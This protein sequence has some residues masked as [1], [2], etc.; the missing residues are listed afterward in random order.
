MNIKSADF[1]IS[2]VKSPQFPKNKLPEFAFIGRSNV[3][4]SSLINML[5]NRKLLAKTS[6]KP[7]KTRLLNFFCINNEWNLVDMPGYGYAKASKTNR[8]LFAKI[9]AEYLKV[10]K[11]LIYLFILI[12][13]RH[14]P[15]NTDMEFIQQMAQMQ[16][17]FVFV[18]TKTDKLSKTA[19]EKS[20]QK[21][22]QTLDEMFEELP[23]IFLASSVSCMGREELLSFIQKQSQLY[24]DDIKKLKID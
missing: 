6:S 17:P 9:I 10:R 12:D 16:I 21:Y 11:S 4:K 1:L 22:K 2:A 8:E 18:F 3:G 19:L 20:I 13:A 24:A 5:T 23:P 15:L 7:G 14:Q